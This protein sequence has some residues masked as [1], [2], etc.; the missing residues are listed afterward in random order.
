MKK[1][2]VFF[3]LLAQFTFQ[4]Q[5]D[6]FQKD[7]LPGAGRYAHIA[8][9]IGDKAYAGLGA[10]N[11]ELRIYSAE[12]FRYDPSEDSWEQL[13]DFPGGARFGPCAFSCNGKGYVCLGVDQTFNWLNEVWEFDPGTEIWTQKSDFPGGPRYHSSLF[14]IDN[15]AYIAGGSVNQGNN[16]LNDLWCYDPANDSWTRRANLPTDHLA[17]AVGF[18]LDGNGYLAGGGHSTYEVS[19]DVYKYDPV[20]NTWSQ[21]PDLPGLRAGAVGFVIG[22]KAYVGTGT[23]HANTYKSFWYYSQETNNWTAM[24]NPP[25]D[26]SQRF[27]STA[28]SIGDTGYVFGGRSEPYD[29]YYNNGKMLNDLWAFMPC[30]LPEAGFTFQVNNFIVNFTDSSS[31][32]TQ[33]YWDFGDG[34]HS[35]EKD[36]VHNFTEGF[37]HVCLTVTNDCGQDTICKEIRIECPDPHAGFLYTFSFPEYQF[38]DTSAVGYLISRLWDFG[39]STFSTEPNPEHI[40]NDPGTYH[41]CLIV[42]DSCG[43]DS[44]CQDI[45]FLLPLAPQISITL[46]A[47]NDL[48]AQFND[49]TPGTTF[50]K[51]K[52]G[53]GD[54]SELQSPSHLYKDY[55]TYAV[56]LAAGNQ[57]S[58]GTSCDTLLL[59]VNPSLH[60][61]NPLLVY[62][63]PTEDKLFIRF[64]RTCSST[65]VLI[66]DQSGKRIFNQHLSS[67]DLMTPLKI[68]LSG[69]SAG[70]YFVQVKCD[71]Y[72]KM[73][74]IVKL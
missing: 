68:D 15:K 35:T 50:R 20:T 47:S 27:A 52:F 44:A 25:A 12:M 36:P 23:D 43:I 60:V 31:G 30:T 51:W 7:S 13:S 66:D 58:F 55:G 22:E 39:D 34:T 8:F 63:N 4:G 5:T 19:Q 70:V 17:G 64:Y 28:F 53:D 6:W 69:L 49:E 38:T 29:P 59:S 41:V 56:C 11:A 67:P 72:N 48:L 26:F 57:Q 24:T 62:P 61:D 71:D 3:F 33:Y 21:L 65:E 45:T 74:K 14:V 32:A 18:S 54:S 73:L 16:Y 37:F 2:L 42:T 10:I 46:S 9:V 40:Y 1:F